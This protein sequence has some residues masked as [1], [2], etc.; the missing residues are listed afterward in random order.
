ME[1]Q[2]LSAVLQDRHAYEEIK[3]YVEEGDLSDI[4]AILYQHVVEYYD[5]DRE[6]LHVDLDLLGS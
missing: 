4:G 2:V 3:Q 1:K 5:V 6:A